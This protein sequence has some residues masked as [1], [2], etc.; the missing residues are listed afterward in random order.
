MG[1]GVGVHSDDQINDLTEQERQMLKQ[2]IMMQLQNSPEIRQ[3]ILDEAGG[4]QGV[5]PIFLAHNPD[6]KQRLVD[7]SA[8][9]L[10]RL[11]RK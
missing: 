8:E 7:G 2:F 3:M 4:A 11:K 10:Q 1:S 9:L 6:I 5:L